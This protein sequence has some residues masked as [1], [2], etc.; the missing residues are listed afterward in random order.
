MGA[1]I[2]LYNTIALGFTLTALSKFPGTQFFPIMGV[3][4]VMLDVV[5]AHLVWKE[6]L[7]LPAKIGAGVSIAAIILVMR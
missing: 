2:G 4:V 5:V 6:P 7:S 3:S 1:G